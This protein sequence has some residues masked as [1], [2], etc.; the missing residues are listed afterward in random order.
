MAVTIAGPPL[1]TALQGTVEFS[2]TVEGVEHDILEYRIDNGD[3]LVGEELSQMEVGSQDWSFTWNSNSVD[4]GSH[5]I[6]FR[7]VNESGV[8]T[9]DIRR[10]YTVDNQPAAPDFLF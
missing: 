3:W 4:D 6:A 1:G 10:T 5:R 9:D 2:G 7:M 8:V